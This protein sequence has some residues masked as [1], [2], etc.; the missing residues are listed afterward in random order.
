MFKDTDEELE[1]LKAALLRD[2]GPI[3]LE[4]E[5]LPLDDDLKDAEALLN[6][7]YGLDEEPETEEEDFDAFEDLEDDHTQVF[8]VV[9]AQHSSRWIANTDEAD[10]DL[11]E[12]SEEVEKG[13]DDSDIRKLCVVALFLLLG[14]L[15]VM[16][17][18]Y[19]RYMGLLG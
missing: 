11:D 10:V 13:K 19:M 17:W 6:G 18:L 3:T 4:D 14:I 2:D 7:T 5:D 8:P 9:P 16:G 1:R 12:L 15:V